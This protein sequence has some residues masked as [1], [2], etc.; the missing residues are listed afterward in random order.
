MKKLWRASLRVYPALSIRRAGI[1]WPVGGG[2]HEASPFSDDQ[3]FRVISPFVRTAQVPTIFQ[4]HF[5][6]PPHG[7]HQGGQKDLLVTVKWPHE[8]T[9]T[10]WMA[11]T[12]VRPLMQT[13][14]K[15]SDKRELQDLPAQEPDP[16]Q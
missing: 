2:H 3:A 16:G 10:L 8:V 13:C 6:S 12:P 5:E 4:P 15:N 1:L 14:P 9:G 11:Q 7:T